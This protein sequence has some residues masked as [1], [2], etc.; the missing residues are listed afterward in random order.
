MKKISLITLCASLIVSGNKA[1]SL[2]ISLFQPR[3]DSST[4]QAANPNMFNFSNSTVIAD[5]EDIARD[6]INSQKSNL[7]ISQ[8][9]RLRS[10]TQKI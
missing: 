8:C 7:A 3:V 10:T 5:P 4:Q 2:K 6:F 9:L 1:N